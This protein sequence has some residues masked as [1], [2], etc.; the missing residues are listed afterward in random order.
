LTKTELCDINFYLVRSN[1]SRQQDRRKARTFAENST[2]GN[3]YS[4][5]S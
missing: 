3:F 1:A 4:K 2:G 5:R